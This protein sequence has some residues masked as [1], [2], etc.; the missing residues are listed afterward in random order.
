[1]NNVL[2]TRVYKTNRLSRGKMV[3][4]YRGYYTLQKNGPRTWRNLGTPDKTIA[5][6]RIMAFAVEAQREA[7]GL[8]APKSQREANARGLV[9]LLSEYEADLTSL[10][11]A[12]KHVRDTAF[13]IRRVLTET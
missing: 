12:A 2:Y 11:R 10:G 4:S 5:E 1:M 9:A 6:K 3:A 7:E 13:R 8:I